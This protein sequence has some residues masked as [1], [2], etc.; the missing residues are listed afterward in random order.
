MLT[1]CRPIHLHGRTFLCRLAATQRRNRND[2]FELFRK[3]RLVVFEDAFFKLG[4]ALADRPILPD[5][6]QLQNVVQKGQ[7]NT[8]ANAF[9][10]EK[11]ARLSIWIRKA[12]EV[13]VSSIVAEAVY[14]SYRE[15]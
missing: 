8:G 9:V 1:V 11:N 7:Q 6:V 5:L 12:I 14:A 3:W 4:Q 2:S 10:S 15:M 13:P